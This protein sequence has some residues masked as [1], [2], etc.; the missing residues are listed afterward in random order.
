MPRMGIRATSSTDMPA[1]DGRNRPDDWKLLR[2]R[3]KSLPDGG[4][5]APPQR[6]P[7]STQRAAPAAAEGEGMLPSTEPEA[8][9]GSL[10]KADI[11]DG[12]PDPACQAAW[13]SEGREAAVAAAA[14]AEARSAATGEFT[15]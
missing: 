3:R 6:S 8:P 14:A 7:S 13:T 2:E 11:G 15:L 4:A 10:V 1:L 12:H 5:P 9:P